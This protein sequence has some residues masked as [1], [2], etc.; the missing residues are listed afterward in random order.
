[1]IGVQAADADAVYQA[2]R[3]GDLTP[4]ESADTFA[5]GIGARV[6][7]TVPL[8][9]M[10]ERLDGLFTVSETAI[11]E[12]VAALFAEERILIEGACAPPISVMDRL[13][14]ELAGNTIAI[15]ITGRN[16]PLPKVMQA[17]RTDNERWD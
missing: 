10:R 16:L 7:F 11:I 8:E 2:W 15:P 6:P 14:D 12:T 4:Q 9:V 5:E 13:R 17:L 1:M 3:T